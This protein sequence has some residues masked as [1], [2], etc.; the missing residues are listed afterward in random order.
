MIYRGPVF[1]A[2]VW[3]GSSPTPSPPLSRQQ[4]VSLYV[5]LSVC[6]WSS[7]LTGEGGE[8]VGE[9]PNNTAAR[10]PGPLLIIR[11]YLPKRKEDNVITTNAHISTP[12]FQKIVFFFK[13]F[14]GKPPSKFLEVCLNL[15]YMW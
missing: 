5:S 6:R 7:L 14:F 9:E 13:I 8:G 11:Y 4:L 1:L 3:L 12:F 10:K 15:K 2:V